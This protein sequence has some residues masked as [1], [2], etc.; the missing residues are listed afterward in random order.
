M[1]FWADAG[2][3]YNTGRLY[4]T[5]RVCYLDWKHGTARGYTAYLEPMSIV[6]RHAQS[7]AS[8]AA[9]PGLIWAHYVTWASRLPSRSGP[10]V[11]V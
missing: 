5:G 9:R 4:D 6:S 3:L 8:P 11:H 1:T 10:L 2:C 7:L